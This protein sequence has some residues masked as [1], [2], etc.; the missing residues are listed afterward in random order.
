MDN[1]KPLPTKVN[2]T[3]HSVAYWQMRTQW[4]D[5]LNLKEP[6]PGT[7]ARYLY[8]YPREDDDEFAERLK[9]LAQVNFVDAVIE[10]Y[11]AMLFSTNVQI[12]SEKYPD[13][14]KSFAA[15]CTGQGDSLVDYFRDMVAPNAFLYGITDVFVDLPAAMD[16][17]ISL[18]AQRESGIDQPYCYIV[19]A[20][21][22]TR[23]DIGTDGSY[24]MYVSEDVINTQVAAQMGIQ[25]PRQRQEWTE[26][27]EWRADK[28]TVTE[29]E[30]AKKPKQISETPNPFGL[31]PA[32][33]VTPLASMRFFNDRIG[34]SLVKD[35][36]P[37][38]KLVLN[39]MSLLMDAQENSNFAQRYI[40]QDTS[41][42]DMPPEE[43]EL[44][45]AGPKRGVVL[46]GANSKFGIASPDASGA[47]AMRMYLNDII[48]RIYQSAFIEAGTDQN[49]THQS[50]QTIRSNNARLYNRL[51]KISKNLE[52]SMKRV[53]EMS[54]RVRGI[55]PKEAKVSV[56][57]DTNFSYEAFVSALEELSLLRETAGDI[58]TTLVKEFVKK[59]VGPEVY[60]SGKIDEIMAEI[61]KWQPAPQQNNGKQKGKGADASAPN[62]P[63]PDVL[64]LENSAIKAS[65]QVSDE[66]SV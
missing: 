62:T 65:Q 32:V 54:L 23:W 12:A 51:S 64:R 3:S 9:R 27:T 1:S 14:V 40:I 13:E 42:G 35:I 17:P 24:S 66:P 52:K 19:P 5:A 10:F 53:V 8:K 29:K 25:D 31:I 39:L 18:Q 21:N 50:A 44:K 49:K 61:D 63:Q 36:V 45:E 7:L 6:L 30:G 56:Q 16:A 41:N 37:L 4:I 2:K 38:Q 34:V 22:R 47:E 20:L 28:V 60:N 58:S 55:D 33:S 26:E 15:D 59:T 11:C 48:D 57:W 43:G 46:Y